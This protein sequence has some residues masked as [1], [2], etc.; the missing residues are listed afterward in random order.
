MGPLVIN[1]LTWLIG[2]LASKGTDISAANIENTLR[3]MDILNLLDDYNKD[4]FSNHGKYRRCQSV[5]LG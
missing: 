4:V 5:Q 1:G 3:S 2:H